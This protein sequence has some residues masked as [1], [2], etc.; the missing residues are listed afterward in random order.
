MVTW[1]MPEAELLWQADHWWDA[2]T[3]WQGDLALPRLD[4]HDWRNMPRM[5]AGPVTTV[6]L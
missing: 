6:L 3:Y 5:P 4:P 1:F 2:V